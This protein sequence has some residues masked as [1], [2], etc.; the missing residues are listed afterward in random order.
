MI[1]VTLQL[2]SLD[3]S[4][5]NT[6]IVDSSYIVSSDFAR[7]HSKLHCLVHTIVSRV[8]SIILAPIFT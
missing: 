2:T 7:A 4:A 1:T 8:E 5:F 3:M 6:S